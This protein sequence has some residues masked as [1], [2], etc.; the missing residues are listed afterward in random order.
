MRVV[1]LLSVGTAALTLTACSLPKTSVSSGSERPT[2]AIT[3]AP[4]M[5]TLLVD[6][7]VIGDATRYDGRNNIVKIEEGTHRVSI[8]L[9]G[10]VIHSEVIHARS[11]ESMVV[12][13]GVAAP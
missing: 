3:G 9:N 7:I 5:S 6:G 11:N 13:A 8:Q 4:A 1:H 12:E 10:A 2:L